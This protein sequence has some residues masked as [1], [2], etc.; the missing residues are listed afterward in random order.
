[1]VLSNSVGKWRAPDDQTYDVNVRLEPSARNN[2][3]DLARLPLMIAQAPDGAGRSVTLGEVARLSADTGSSQI[4]RRDL[5]REVALNAN[6][7]G[8]T[9]GEIST[10]IRR[11]HW[12]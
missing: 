5:N 12:H 1:M 2:P 11:T 8:R 6:A 9:V 3:Q 10:D 7:S 4:N